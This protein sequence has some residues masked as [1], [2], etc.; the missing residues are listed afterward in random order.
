[1]IIMG[2]MYMCGDLI[3]QKLSTTIYRQFWSMAGPEEERLASRK[4]AW[5]R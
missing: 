3:D 4:P 5:E 1:M 2:S